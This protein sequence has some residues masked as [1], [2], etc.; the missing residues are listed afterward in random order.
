[1]GRPFL[2]HLGGRKY[3]TCARC[4]TYLSN[5][6]EILSHT[7]RGDIRQIYSICLYTTFITGATGQAY[8]FRN[9]VNIT[10]SKVFLIKVN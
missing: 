8:L 3:Y 5:K 9:V 2:E 4:K 1:M 6:K 10:T 7:F